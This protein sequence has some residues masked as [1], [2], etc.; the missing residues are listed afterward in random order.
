[1]IQCKSLNMFQGIVINYLYGL[2]FTYNPIEFNILHL[3]LV[4]YC[5]SVE[6]ITLNSSFTTPLI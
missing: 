6:I 5:I 3:Q 1:M 4:I 2:L